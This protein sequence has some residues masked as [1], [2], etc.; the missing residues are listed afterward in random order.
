MN[1]FFDRHH[2]QDML[3]RINHSSG[4]LQQ[5]SWPVVVIVIGALCTAQVVAGDTRHWPEFLQVTQARHSQSN[6]P[7]ARLHTSEATL[8]VEVAQSREE[9]AQGLMQRRHLAHQTGMIFLFARDA[10][11]TFWMKNTLIPL[12][13]VFIDAA[14]KVVDIVAADPC[15]RDPCPTYSPRSAARYVLEVGQRQARALGLERGYLL[16]KP[17]PENAVAPESR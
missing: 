11:H 9:R 15:T 5:L 7:I 17:A 4:I 6:L 13:M 16:R 2:S 12:D 3:S 10:R 8:A 14:G 1:T